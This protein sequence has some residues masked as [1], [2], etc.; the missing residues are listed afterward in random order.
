V[1]LPAPT[2]DDVAAICARV[3]GRILRLIDG[4]RDD[5]TAFMRL[6]L[7]LCGPRFDRRRFRS[8][9]LDRRGSIAGRFVQRLNSSFNG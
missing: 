9:R 5:Q 2:D 4:D 7:M 6:M 3:A 1:P 8:P